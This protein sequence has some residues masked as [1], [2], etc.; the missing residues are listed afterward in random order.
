MHLKSPTNTK[1]GALRTK[2]M[3]H[4]RKV[5]KRRDMLGQSNLGPRKERE[6]KDLRKCL[7]LH[8]E[9]VK[10]CF[11]YN[12]QDSNLDKMTEVIS[13]HVEAFVIADRHSNNA[14]SGRTT[15]FYRETAKAWTQEQNVN[16]IKQHYE[17]GILLMQQIVEVLELQS[18]VLPISKAPL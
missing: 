12:I 15:P 17:G 3:A 14:T 4:S 7:N 10:K 8:F 9:T 11:S 16:K 2:Q 1:K 18:S 5:F 6:N 13:E